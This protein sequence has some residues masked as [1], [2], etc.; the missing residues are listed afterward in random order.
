MTSSDHR[1]DQTA[2]PPDASAPR[3]P[4]SLA[5]Q[6]ALVEAAQRRAAIDRKMAERPKEIGGPDGSEPTRYGDWENKGAA[7]DF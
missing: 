2:P 5:A 6:R 1:S 7:S 3:K 4:L